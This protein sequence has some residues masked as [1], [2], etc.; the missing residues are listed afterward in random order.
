[1][2]IRLLVPITSTS[3]RTDAHLELMA[4]PGVELSVAFLEAGPPSIESRVDE[5]F[6][7]PSLVAKARR[8]EADGVDALVID[9]MAD[10]GLAILREA[11]RIPVLG[12]A[13]TAMSVATNLA[14]TFGVVTVLDSL[15]P[16]IADL[17]AIYGY[18]R[19]Y[20]GTRGISVPVLAIESNIGKV[21]V[22]LAEEALRLVRHH[23]AQA[24]ILGCTG[25][26]GCTRAIQLRLQKEGYDIPV[27]DPLPTAVLV[28]PALVRQGLSHSRLAYPQH[29]FTKPIAEHVRD[30]I[31]GRNCAAGRTPNPTDC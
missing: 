20:V 12:V 3:V 30:G 2:H 18:A 9:C 14:Q 27:I 7:L 21:Q 8:A 23:G 5:A 28:A 16:L 15:A 4:Q 17:A 10:P 26:F 1:M 11:V 29:D 24:I 13:Q 25:F 31:L 22:A 19:Q 6:A